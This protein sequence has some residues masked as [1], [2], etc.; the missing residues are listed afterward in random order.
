MFK[1]ALDAGHGMDT[2]GKRC[3]KSLDPK[4]TR[5]WYLNAR[6]CDKV[7]KQLQDY[8]GYELL[9]VDDVT[10]KTDI[11]LGTRTRKANNWGADFYLS[12]HHNAGLCGKQGGGVVTIVYTNPSAT[13]VKYQKIVH[14]SFI[15]QTGKFGNRADELPR[16]NL[17]VC[18]ETNMPSVLIECGFMDSPT[19]VPMILSEAFAEKAARGLT[20]ALVKIG[21]LKKRN[22]NVVVQPQLTDI[23]GHYAENHIKKLVDC[24][25]IK[26][27]EDNTFKPENNITRA[28]F[29]TLV[30]NALEKVCG[31]TLG[32]SKLFPDIAGHWAAKSIQKIAT[33]G[34][35][36]GYEDGNFR[37]DNMITRGQAA[38]MASNMLL[39]CGVNMKAGGVY[40]DTVGHYAERHICNLNAFG[41]INGYED[42]TFKPDNNIT[43]GQAA[44][45][46]ANCLTVLGK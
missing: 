1:I 12:V 35:A 2:P 18:R 28:E 39:Y 41:I 8:T 46:V 40:P 16:M 24:N 29:S 37:P 44:I 45:I 17:H 23:S 25:V 21:G 26:G 10:G 5:E 36:N 34:I 33:C 31:H 3:L 15:A 14:E 20:N 30:V 6:I 27:Y 43:R 11:P 38:I 32:A 9:R 7:A 4:E 42:G 19:D 22:N 13:S